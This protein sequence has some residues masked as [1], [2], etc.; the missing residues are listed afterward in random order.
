MKYNSVE[1]WRAEAERRFGPDPLK[2]RFR[3]PMCGHVASVED[4]RIVGADSPDVAWQE[5]IGRYM[6]KGT[7]KDGDD[8]GCDWAAYGLLGIPREHD[9]IIADDGTEIHA[10]PLADVPR[11]ADLELL[12]ASGFEI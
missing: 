4:F 12:E 1:E 2:W 9:I 7:P 8:S 11:R 5:C 6:G 10:Y 3:C